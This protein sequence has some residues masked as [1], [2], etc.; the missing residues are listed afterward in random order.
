MTTPDQHTIHRN[1]PPSLWNMHIYLYEGARQR[2]V[3]MMLHALA[4]GADKNFMNESDH[5]RTPLIQA[6]LG[7][8]CFVYEYE[9]KLFYLF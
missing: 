6:I 2:N 8:C 3:L 1:N 4:L 5:G 9:M 7:V